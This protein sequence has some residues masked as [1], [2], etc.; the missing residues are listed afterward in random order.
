VLARIEP[1][2]NIEPIIE[3]HLQATDKP[4]VIIGGYGNKFGSYLYTKY[5]SDKIQ[6]WGAVYD[7][8]VLNCLR[9]Y[10]YLYFHGH[11][12]GGTNPSLLEAMA[13]YSLIAA[14]E[15]VFN[16][17]IL[18]PDAFYF[19]NAGDIEKL[20]RKNVKRADYQYALDNNAN[21]IKHQYS[22]ENIITQL[23]KFLTHAVEES[24]K[25]RK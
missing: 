4:L 15:N 13:S 12:V 24:I 8:D 10:A 9:Y 18:G 1:E 22:W 14:H 2:N 11:S 21:K 6:F 20:L 17:T 3:A 19:S 25:R 16:Q 23:E 7:V 5:S